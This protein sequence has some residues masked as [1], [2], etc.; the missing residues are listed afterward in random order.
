MRNLGWQCLSLR[1]R[2]ARREVELLARETV[3]PRVVSRHGERV[4]P[5]WV[6]DRS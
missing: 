3:E 6:D 4:R 2:P 1:D 5:R